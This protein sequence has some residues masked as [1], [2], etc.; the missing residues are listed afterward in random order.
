MAWSDHLREAC[1]IGGAWVQADSGATIAVT[2]PATGKTLGTVPKMGRAECARAIDAAH[3]AFLA[4]GALTANER[5]GLMMTLYTALMDNQADLGELLCREMGKPLAEAR[6]EVAYG[7]S[8]VK[9]FAEETRRIYGDTIPSPWAGK[10]IM[11]THAPVGVVGAITP[12]NF[13]TAMIA[14]KLGA[15]LG[16]GCAMVCKPATAT[17]Y[18]ALAFGALVE[19]AGFPKGIFNVITGSASEIAAEMCE[20]PRLRKITFTGSTEV[21]KSLASAALAHMK[22]VS[23]EL[24][25]NAPFIVFDDADLDAAVA[26]AMVSKYRNS[27]QTCVCA[28][29]F[30]VQRGV[31]DAF[32][33][34][35]KTAV[36]A[37]KVG[38]GYD[39]GVT[40]G[41]LIDDAA[42]AKVEEHL[43]DMIAGGATV[44]TG[45]KRIGNEG[46]FFAPTVVTGATTAMKPFSEE[47]FGPIAPVFV[48]DT[49]A[50]AI[51]MAN[52][53]PFGLASY[54]YT[55]DLG[56]AYRVM[57]A[58]EYGMV[59]VNEGLIS[60][61]VAPF[62][63]VKE[64]GM[65]TEGS[66]Y[67]LDDYL[68]KKY[69]LFGGLG[70]RG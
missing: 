31:H 68:V 43:A 66:K 61:E 2:D 52:D 62:G 10:R 6:G 37:L 42:L 70:V 4:Y 54:F 30:L 15:A 14:R 45:G 67:G 40:Q 3:A 20:N 48:F 7:A 38:R 23:M 55:R 19:A 65:G 69:A 26:G 57:E 1:L 44:I 58:L 50:E 18:S 5:A 56:R 41:P 35:L 59:G 47:T 13:P 60:C 53:T 46:A 27:G 9:W 29:R 51:A 22:R 12:W 25:G 24:G 34:K 8:F 36:E 17:P 64:S 39:E 33:A 49:E 32:V 28:N 16:A 63:G 21:G 11:V